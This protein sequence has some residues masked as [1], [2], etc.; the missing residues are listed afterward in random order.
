MSKTDS[1]I[2][3]L[4]LNAAYMLNENN[5]V[6]DV[7]HLSFRSTSEILDLDI[8]AVATH[9][10]CFSICE[11]P[12]NIKDD[13]ICKLISKG[14]LLGLN[15]YSPFLGSKRLEK[16][17]EHIE[18]IKRLGGENIIAL[19]C[20]FD[21]CDDLPSGINGVDDISRLYDLMPCPDGLFYYNVRNFLKNI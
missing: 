15:L 12:R 3:K 10:C 16:V 13:A 21:G 5:I 11:H 17:I 1:G 20:D 8:K 2:S 4:G 18:H 19:G 7:S 9:S 6:S 14:G